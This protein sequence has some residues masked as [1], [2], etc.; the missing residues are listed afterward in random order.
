VAQQWIRINSPDSKSA[1]SDFLELENLRLKRELEAMKN[2]RRI[3]RPELGDVGGEEDLKIL[4]GDTSSDVQ[5][6]ELTPEQLKRG[7]GR[8]RKV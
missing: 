2:G 5:V 1:R 7:P 3:S 6:M 8:P 4:E